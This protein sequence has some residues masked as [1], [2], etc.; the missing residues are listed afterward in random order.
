MSTIRILTVFIIIFYFQFEYIIYLLMLL[1]LGGAL[2][3]Y[4]AKDKVS[5]IQIKMAISNLWLIY[6]KDSC[7]L[8]IKL[9]KI[10]ALRRAI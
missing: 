5:L 2:G 3:M 8:K 7:V 10:N 1:E 9:L 6:V 4:F